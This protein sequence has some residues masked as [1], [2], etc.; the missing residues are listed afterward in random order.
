ML[1]RAVIF[2][3][4]VTAGIVEKHVPAVSASLAARGGPRRR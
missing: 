1:G 4:V 2:H 3:H